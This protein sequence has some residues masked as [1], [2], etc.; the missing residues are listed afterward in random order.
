MEIPNGGFSESGLSD[1]DNQPYHEVMD[2]I[3]VL[4]ELKGSQD[5]LAEDMFDLQAEI[6]ELE[7]MSSA[8]KE[9][10]TTEKRPVSWWRDR[11]DKL[12]EIKD[13]LEEQIT[14]KKDERQNVE[15][16]MMK[17][18]KHIEQIKNEIKSFLPK[19]SADVPNDQNE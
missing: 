14:Q 10:D 2:T 1:K 11:K 4:K 13:S 8:L 15:A 19:E 17:A 3:G 12:A 5:A 16:A 18:R 6:N 9:K 7:R